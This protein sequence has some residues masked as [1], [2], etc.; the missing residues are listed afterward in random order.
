MKK[1]IVKRTSLWLVLLAGW[2]VSA[3]EDPKPPPQP[4]PGGQAPGAPPQAGRD[5]P[6][7]P[8]PGG[9]GGM[10]GQKMKIVKRFDTDGDKRLNAAE[11]KAARQFLEKER[12]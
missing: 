4:A 1:S 11:R 7:G 2:T 9:F 6:G 3:Q 5:G 10:M 12:A 8:G